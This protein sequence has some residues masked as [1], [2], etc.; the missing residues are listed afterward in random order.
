MAMQYDVQ[1]AH[2]NVSSQMVVGRTRV[3]GIVLGGAAGVDNADTVPYNIVVPGEGMIADN[4]VYA[5]LVSVPS[6]EIFY[7]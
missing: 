4:G 3:K 6:V 1:S 5:Q 2:A 7:G